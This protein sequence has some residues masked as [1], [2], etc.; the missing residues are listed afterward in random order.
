MDGEGLVV[1][2]ELDRA[3]PTLVGQGRQRQQPQCLLTDRLAW[4]EEMGERG[5][6]SIARNMY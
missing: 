4:G 5:T 1:V 2:V 6:V 3:F